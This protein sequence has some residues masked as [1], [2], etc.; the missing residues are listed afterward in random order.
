[1]LANEE[2]VSRTEHQLLIWSKGFV[3]MSCRVSVG[4]WRV[5]F[6]AARGYGTSRVRLV[7]KQPIETCV[8]V[9]ARFIAAS[10]HIHATSLIH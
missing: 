4:V 9:S 3:H 10:N 2:H 1:M 8:N 5:M 6:A 7:D